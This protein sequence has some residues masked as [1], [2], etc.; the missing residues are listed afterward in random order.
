ME[1]SEGS[2]MSYQSSLDRLIGQ[3]GIVE[4]TVPPER[5]G[6]GVVKVA[7]Q[8]WSCE[9]DWAEALEAGTTVLVMSR[10]NLILAVLPERI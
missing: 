6:I 3:T 4:D 7:G 5:R 10:T 8:L 9:T 2:A 1:A